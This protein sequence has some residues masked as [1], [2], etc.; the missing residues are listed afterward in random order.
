ML[1]K[2]GFG[3]LLI[4]GHR[5]IDLERL[6]L[7]FKDPETHAANLGEKGTSARDANSRNGGIG[8]VNNGATTTTN[9]TTTT[10]V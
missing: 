8:G 10:T 1:A 7:H 2:P 4:W 9:T 3:A 5:N 6:G